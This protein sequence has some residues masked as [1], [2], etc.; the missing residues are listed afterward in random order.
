MHKVIV[1][2]LDIIILS[3]INN[4]LDKLKISKAK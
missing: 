1:K 4:V 3:K 2:T